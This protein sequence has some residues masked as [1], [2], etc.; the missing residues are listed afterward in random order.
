MST[1]AQLLAQHRR[2]LVLDAA[3]TRTQVGLLG[4]NAAPVWFAT[5]AEA[6]TALFDGTRTVLENAGVELAAVGAFVFC[7]GPGS[8]LGTRTIAMALRTW[9]VLAPRPAYAYRS[10][11]VA[12]H[13]AWTRQPRAFAVIADARRDFWHVQSVNADGKLGPGQRAAAAEMPPGELLT[14][15]YF[16]AWAPPPRP[17]AVCSY[18]LAEIF[19]TLGECEF[20]QAVGAPDSFQSTPP[21]YRKWSAQVHQ[22]PA[23]NPP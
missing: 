2:I 10:L 15:E 6:G 17:A 20:F 3:S 16:R 1:L 7:D 8:M 14:P 21:Q 19:G 13:F 12:G 11:A 9:Q 4:A 5:E 22:A 18:G 23:A